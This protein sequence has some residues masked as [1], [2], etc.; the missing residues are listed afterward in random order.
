MKS[1]HR[2]QVVRPLCPLQCWGPSLAQQ[3]VH[4]LGQLDAR[5]H[6]LHHSKTHLMQLYQLGLALALVSFRPTFKSWLMNDHFV[7]FTNERE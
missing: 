5:Q 6:C 4:L 7:P 1:I 2:P 3:S